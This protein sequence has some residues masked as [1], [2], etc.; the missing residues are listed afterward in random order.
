VRLARLLSRNTARAVAVVTALAVAGAGAF[1]VLR[2]HRVVH[3]VAHFTRAVGV[4]P[5][6]DVRVLGVRIGT[7]TRVTPE[8][9]TVRVEMEYEAD[10]RVPADAVAV[11]VPPSL[12][13][14]RYV[15]L[16]PVYRGGPV[17]AD[18]ADIPL[19]RTASP[20]ELDEIYRSLDDLSVALGP[21]GANRDGALSRLL[22]VG[23][24]NLDGNGARINQGLDDLDSAV[25]TLSAHRDDLFGSVR[26][27]QVFVSAL[28]DSDRQV[29]QFNS[30]LASV[31]R[32][33][34]DERV[35]LAAA[36]KNLAA[37]LD[38]VTSFVRD[39]RAALRADVAGL[40]Q[41]TGTLVRQR[42]ALAEFLDVAPAALS[43]VSNAYDPVSGTLDT[44]NNFNQL[45]DP[46]FVCGLL[47]SLP[48]ASRAAAAVVAQCRQAAQLSQAFAASLTAALRTLGV[49]FAPPQPA[50][51]GVPAA[52][53]APAG[54]PPAAAG[55]LPTIPG[56]T[57]RQQPPDLLPTIP[58]V[59]TGGDV[60]GGLTGAIGALL[61]GGS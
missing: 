32:Q 2:P 42:A 14:D 47:M 53:A 45:G 31:A 37:A 57:A 3:V 48:A 8:G 50:G 33:L 56:V 36:L 23:A 58:G 59:G 25:S 15:Q 4:Y 55:E 11:V 6:S 17:L 9:A 44:R 34:A 1:V 38:Q 54:S 7:I 51:A 49:P 13:S 12:V 41:V 43:N 30:D 46:A 18:G 21:Q 16:A 27:L 10:R 52:P 20:V 61:G 24:D 28:A 22:Q 40:A 35:S 29:R 60:T 39:N 26:N 19:S 5:G